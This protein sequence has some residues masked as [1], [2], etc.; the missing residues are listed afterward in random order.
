MRKEKRKVKASTIALLIVLLMFSACA[1]SAN[2]LLSA[3]EDEM[4]YAIR[5]MLSE[6]CNRAFADLKIMISE[7]SFIPPEIEILD[8]YKETVPGLKD[9]L[10]K[11][12]ED[13][14]DSFLNNS[15]TLENNLKSIISEV[16][17]KNPENIVSSNTK[18]GS[19]MLATNC[20]PQILQCFITF[21]N[22]HILYLKQAIN[23]FN[24][25]VSTNNRISNTDMESIKLTEQEVN[26]IISDNLCNNLLNY[27][28]KNEDL[29]RTTPNSSNPKIIRQVFNI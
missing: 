8:N 16:N 25:Y 18:S 3:T 28:I 12:K 23:Q 20:Y 22:E 21:I 6:V 11:W 2:T 10:G 15:K 17:I 26:R 19:L 24:I 1:G 14:T 5:L 9:I 7:Y 13:I 29:Y 4:I 27:F